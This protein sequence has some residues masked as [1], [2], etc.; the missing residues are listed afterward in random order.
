MDAMGELAET[1]W[2]LDEAGLDVP[3]W[4]AAV[5]DRIGVP[6]VDRSVVTVFDRLRQAGFAP[7]EHVSVVCEPVRDGRL[8]PVRSDGSAMM[9]G[10]PPQVGPMPGGW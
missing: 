10:P 9:R 4:V 5:N 2:V 1:A 6:Q 3:G 8:V 7:G